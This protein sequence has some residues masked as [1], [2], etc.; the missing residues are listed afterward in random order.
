MRYETQA[1]IL[2][3]LSSLTQHYAAVSLSLTVTRSFDATRM[4]TLGAIAAVTDVVLRVEACD[5]PSQL[6]L[7]YGGGGEGP[8]SPYCFDAATHFA[9]ESEYCRFHDPNLAVA[10]T[11]L[12]DYFIARRTYY[13]SLTLIEF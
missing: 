12:L 11:R 7:H 1:D 13:Q 8:V 9:L 4:C 6:S 3:L 2:R 5:V 10:R